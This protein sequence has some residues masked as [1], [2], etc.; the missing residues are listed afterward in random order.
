MRQ[1]LRFLSRNPSQ[2]EIELGIQALKTGDGEK[3][4]MA[5]AL[6]EY[7][8]TIPAKQA[9]SIA[10]VVASV[11]QYLSSAL[12]RTFFIGPHRSQGLTGL[13]RGTPFPDL[14]SASRVVQRLIGVQDGACCEKST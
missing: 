5:A 10:M 8:K 6:A 11:P 14:L 13:S 4:K 9:P 7:E 2:K 3:A 12:K 1:L